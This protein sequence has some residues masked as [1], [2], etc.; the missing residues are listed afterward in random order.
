MTPVEWLGF[1]VF[2]VLSA[3]TAGGLLTLSL[4]LGPKRTRPERLD[5]YECGVPQ[6]GPTRERFHV[7]FYLVA[8]M[9]MLFDIELVFLMPWA[10]ACRELGTAALIE[11]LIFIGIL[12]FAWLYLIRRRI[13][14]WD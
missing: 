12:M 8:V 4:L 1:G 9:F 2:A 13:L 10:V 14:D 3:L 7:H 6:V 11:V 5:P